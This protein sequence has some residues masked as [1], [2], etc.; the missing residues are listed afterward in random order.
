MSRW[1]N[2]AA[3]VS[4]RRSSGRCSEMRGGGVEHRPYRGQIVQRGSDRQIVRRT[5]A[6]EQSSQT[7]V[8]VAG[9]HAAAGPP[10][11]PQQPRQAAGVAAPSCRTHLSR[12]APDR[13]VNGLFILRRVTR[14]RAD[15]GAVNRVNVGAT[16]EQQR[17]H[18]CRAADDRAVEGMT[19]SA[20]DVANERWLLI[21]EGANAR[22]LAGFGGLMDWMILRR[23]RRHEPSR[24]I[25]HVCGIILASGVAPD[26][27]R[28]L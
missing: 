20:V 26:T 28:K 24:R 10:A 18:V 5:A 3:A 16:I 15:A 9:P 27:W 17:H 13:Q 25:N 7:H 8:A 6:D 23:G 11:S 1:P 2:S 12:A 21:E 22:Q 14:E 4:G 19:A